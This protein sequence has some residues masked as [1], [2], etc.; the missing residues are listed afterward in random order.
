[1]DNVAE[2]YGGDFDYYSY[3]VRD[4]MMNLKI[5]YLEALSLLNSSN[6]LNFFQRIV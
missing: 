5:T 4:V 3:T 1:M 6:A 2:I